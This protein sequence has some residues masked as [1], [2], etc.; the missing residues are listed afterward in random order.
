MK[1]QRV[2]NKGM[3]REGKK[4]LINEKGRKYMHET[5]EA[6]EYK[7]CIPTLNKKKV[8]KSYVSNTKKGKKSQ[9]NQGIFF[10]RKDEISVLR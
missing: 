2:E 9:Q 4:M 1:I 6:K 5:G 3:K 7:K 8:N 10:F